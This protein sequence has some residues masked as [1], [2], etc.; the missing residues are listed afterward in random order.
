MR[1]AHPNGDCLNI[2]KHEKDE[3]NRGMRYAHPNGDYL[4]IEKHEKRRKKWGCATHIL[5]GIV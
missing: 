4:N 2:E 5:M 3:K 1:Y